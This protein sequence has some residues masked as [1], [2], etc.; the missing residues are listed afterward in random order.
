MRRNVSKKGGVDAASLFF[1]LY[2]GAGGYG[3]VTTLSNIM[4]TVPV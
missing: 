3:E 4:V 2:F 1:L